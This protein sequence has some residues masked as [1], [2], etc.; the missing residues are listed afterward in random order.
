MLLASVDELFGRLAARGAGVYGLSA[1]TQLEHALQSAALAQKQG[2]GEALTIAALFHDI[3][4]LRTA[5]DESL[6]D[7]GIDDRHEHAGATILCRLF[8]PEV[9]EPVRL[10]V[11]AKRYLCTVEPDYF[12]RL[13]PDSVRSLGLQGGKLSP[14]ERAA[15]ESEPHF[16]SG[17]ALRRIDDQAKVP[18]LA[19]LG[20]QH[21]REM[22]IRLRHSASEIPA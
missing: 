22:A 9:S 4:H 7:R 17:V 5:S 14:A 12:G 19:V 8:G 20:L 18:G 13:S 1:V 16:R 6:A 11:A 3:G 2:L 10:H 21:Y 15:F